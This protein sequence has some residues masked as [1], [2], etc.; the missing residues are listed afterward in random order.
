MDLSRLELAQNSQGSWAD[1][2]KHWEQRCVASFAATMVSTNRC[3][4]SCSASIKWY[5]KRRADFA[6]TP[7][8]RRNSSTNRSNGFV[9]LE[10]AWHSRNFQISCYST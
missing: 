10:H 5:A 1:K 9:I 6:P 2:L 4:S 7:G 3:T 8:N